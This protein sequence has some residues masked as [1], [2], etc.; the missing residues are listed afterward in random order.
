MRATRPLSS[1]LELVIG[2]MN[3]SSWSLRPWLAL[4]AT[5]HP[6]RERKILLDRPDSR[7]KLRAVSPTGKVPVL[8]AGD[9]MIWESLAI[10]E[11]LAEWFPEAKLWPEDAGVRAVARS[12][13]YEMHG[14]FPD[15]RREMPMNLRARIERAPSAAVQA[16]IDR[17]VALWS[18][19]RTRFGA[20]GPYLFGEFSI[21]D[22]MYAPVVT[23]F[24]TYGVE[25]DAG[26]QAYCEAMLARPDMRAW[27]AGAALETDAD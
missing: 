19:C 6:F 22:C 18:D 1:E 17:I 5:G 8:I 4:R 3:L 21:V 26:A 23:R 16:D 10:C 7:E 25:L 20:G 24:R 14:G 13:A 11:A 15:L 27:Y 9:I 2:N 12:A